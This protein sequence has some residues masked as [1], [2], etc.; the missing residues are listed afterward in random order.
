MVKNPHFHLSSKKKKKEL[1]YW[2]PFKLK[3]YPKTELKRVS[4]KDMD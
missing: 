2:I 1:V 3:T 4:M